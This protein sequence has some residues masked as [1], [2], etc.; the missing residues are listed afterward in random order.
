MSQRHLAATV[1]RL[2]GIVVALLSVTA[3]PASTSQQISVGYGSMAA[4]RR[5]EHWTHGPGFGDRGLRR[6]YGSTCAV[7]GL[8]LSVDEG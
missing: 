3:L 6:H 7:D 4:H 5:G 1:N 2:S 8:D